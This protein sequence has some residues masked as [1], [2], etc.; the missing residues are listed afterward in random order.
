MFIHKYLLLKKMLNGQGPFNPKGGGG[1]LTNVTDDCYAQL[2][3]L[4]TV[5]QADT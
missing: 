2:Y 3:A 1:V 5:R 4:P